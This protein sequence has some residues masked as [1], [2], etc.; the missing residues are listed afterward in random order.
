MEHS[1]VKFGDPSC[2]GFWDIVRINRQTDTQTNAGETL[3]LRLPSS[4]INIIFHCYYT[5]RTD[6]V[7]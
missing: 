5:H 4:W 3:P 1:F 7:L 6:R 2:V